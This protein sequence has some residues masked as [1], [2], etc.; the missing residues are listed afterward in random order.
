[1]LLRAYQKQTLNVKCQTKRRSSAHKTMY[2]AN[3]LCCAR[4]EVF[5]LGKKVMLNGS[6]PIRALMQYGLNI[7]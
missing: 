4:N 5:V 6:V 3:S 7:A 2:A 1:M